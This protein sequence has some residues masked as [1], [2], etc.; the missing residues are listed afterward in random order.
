MGEKTT[1]TYGHPSSGATRPKGRAPGPTFGSPL[2]IMH[3][4]THIGHV[5]KYMKI[6]THAASCVRVHGALLTYLARTTRLR[7]RMA[8][9]RSSRDPLN[10]YVRRVLWATLG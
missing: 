1:L 5:G 9:R 10:T 3:G 7:A 2:P 4:I 6:P 8:H